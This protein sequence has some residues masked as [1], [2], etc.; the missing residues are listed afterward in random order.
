MQPTRSRCVKRTRADA[1][2]LRR[3]R[4]VGAST[5]DAPYAESWNKCPPQFRFGRNPTSPPPVTLA[6]DLPA[7]A[8]GAV[9]CEKM[10]RQDASKSLRFSVLSCIV[11]LGSWFELHGNAR[12]RI[13]GHN[14]AHSRKG[15]RQVSFSKERQE[16]R[17]APRAWRD[18]TE[19]QAIGLFPWKRFGMRLMMALLFASLFAGIASAR[20]RP[21]ASMHRRCRSS[22]KESACGKPSARCASRPSSTRTARSIPPAS[23]SAYPSTKPS[24]PKHGCAAFSQGS[25]SVRM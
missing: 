21:S 5:L 24:S 22:G 13:T 20:R 8:D 1:P 3:Q 17:L 23:T 19:R 2:F 4:C 6:V 15:E 11:W 18:S 9:P 12:S 10:S 25:R 16:Y 7:L 14:D